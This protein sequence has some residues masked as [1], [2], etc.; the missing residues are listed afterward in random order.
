MITEYRGRIPF[1]LKEIKG[2]IVYLWSSN[3]N[4]EDYYNTL[5]DFYVGKILKI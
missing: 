2:N 4:I 1:W 3:K 5:S